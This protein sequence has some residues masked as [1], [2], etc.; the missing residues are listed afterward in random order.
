MR[1]A[2]PQ[3]IV[4]HSEFV[5]QNRDHFLDR[6]SSCRA[7]SAQIEAAFLHIYNS[8]YSAITD[9]NPY[10]DFGKLQSEIRI[11]NAESSSQN[12]A[13]A[14]LLCDIRCDIRNLITPF[15]NETAAQDLPDFSAEAETFKSK[16][17]EIETAYQH[18]GRFED[19][20]RQYTDLT[21]SIAEA[22]IRGDAKS[23]LLCALRCN[24]ALCYSNLGDVKQAW[25]SLEKIPSDVAQGSETYHC[26]WASVAIQHHLE[27]SYPEALK[28]IETA[29]ELKPDYHRAFFF[30]QFLQALLGMKSQEE[31]MTELSS[32]FSKISDER[33]REALSGEYYTVSGFVCTTF[34]DCKNAYENYEKAAA[35]GYN[36]FVSQF[37]MSVALYGQ[38]VKGV[39]YGQRILHPK[40]DI[41]K[42]YEVLDGLKGLLQNE[43]VD[44]RAYQ[45]IKSYTI[46]L[47][48]SVSSIIKGSHDLQPLRL[49]LPFANDYETTRMLLLGSQEP[50]TPEMVQLLDENDQ[51]L[52]DVRQLLQSD[53]PQ[54]CRG[55]I[56]KRL[57]DPSYSLDPDIMLILLQLCIASND[58]QAYRK[59]RNQDGI[60]EYA[61]YLLTAM[62]ACAYELEGETENAKRLFSEVAQTCTDYHVLEN[63]VRFYERSNS[64]QECEKL[65]FKIQTLQKERKMYIDD[66]E[67]FYCVGLDFM[68]SQ[69]RNTAKDFFENVPKDAVTPEAYS[70]MENRLYQAL[71]DPAS[72][73]TAL[74]QKQHAVFQEKMNQAIC[75]RLMCQYDGSLE[76]CLGLLQDIEGLNDEQLVK[77]YW[78]ISDSYLFKKMPDESYSWALKAHKLMEKH[79]YDKSHSAF[80]GRA[81]R[82]GHFE[83]L[84]VI[85]EYQKVH[86]VVVN[87][88]KAVYVSPD[89]DDM[90]QKL[91]QQVEEYLPDAP[92]YAAQEQQLAS[93]YKKQ[94]IPIHILLQCFTAGTGAASYYL[95]ERTSCILAQET[96]SGSNWRKAGSAAILLLMPRRLLLWL[97]AVAFQRCK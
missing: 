78:L 72:L 55:M 43:H 2:S 8:V 65:Y 7:Y 27:D 18:Q 12:Q 25:T 69:R 28:Q 10:S 86:P 79:P 82:S 24:T 83:G 67:R 56:E 30:R 46:S 37:N 6:S 58:V 81:V 57:E 71:N 1:N 31:L 95:P 74:T 92:D 89:E 97:P 90:P 9:I 59:Y 5:S 54:K 4:G 33:Q 68:L 39:P 29:L 94:S 38:A 50:L 75:K 62:D 77:V 84:H 76:I 80:L 63:V 11:Q 45:D 17:K 52:L 19:A 93:D 15:Q 91:L 40:V 34:A 16:I 23:S 26:I 21:I 20:L 22:E 66:L 85:L 87:Y 48:V 3:T 36:R 14:A 42:L 61:G 70:Y 44:K 47:Y 49:C 13:I 51:F 41:P 32:Y 35:H 60:E 53:N 73:Y 88:L 96:L 64:Y